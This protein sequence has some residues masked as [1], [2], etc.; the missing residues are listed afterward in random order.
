MIGVAVAAGLTSAP[1]AYAI[2]QDFNRARGTYGYE[3]TNTAGFHSGDFDG[4]E[5]HAENDGPGISGEF[6]FIGSGGGQPYDFDAHAPHGQGVTNT[7]N[8]HGGY[9]LVDYKGVFSGPLNWFGGIGQSIGSFPGLVFDTGNPNNAPQVPPLSQVLASAD[10]LAPAGKQFRYYINSPYD[11]QDHQ[12]RFVGTGTGA[13]QT[14]GGT[15]M[16]AEQIGGGAIPAN[17]PP[18]TTPNQLAMTVQFG[19]GVGGNEATWDDGTTT[20]VNAVIRLDNLTFTPATVTWGGTIGGNWSTDS[21]WKPLLTGGIPMAPSGRNATAIFGASAS[22][23]TVSLDAP[24]VPPHQG[25][26]LPGGDYPTSNNFYVG[27]LVF[28]S[29]QSYTLAGPEPIHIDTT[30]AN[31]VNLAGPGGLIQAVTGSHTISA[32]V[33]LQRSTTI[34]VASPNTLTISGALSVFASDGQPVTLSKTGGGTAIVNNIR[35]TGS[36]NVAGG[37]L[38][39]APNSTAAGVSYI[40]GNIGIGAAK[41]DITDNKLVT[42]Q[43]AGTWNGSAYTDVTGLV[44]SGR[45][46]SSLPLWDGDGIV[47]SQTFAT[48][49]DYH[50]I[51]VASAADIGITATGVWAGQTVTSTD[52]LV[53]YTYGGDANLDGKINILDY[54]R[55]DQGIAASLTGWSN[56]DFNYDGKVNVLDYA[57]IIDSNIGTQGPAFFTSGDAGNVVAVPE[58][59]S[60]AVILLAASWLAP[61]RRRRLI[62]S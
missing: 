9:F 18:F 40:P 49:G 20:G 55:I 6:F 26:G 36:L 43:T 33:I 5:Y 15:L 27:T 8:D 56:G 3:L 60:A 23:Q 16:Q 54:V 37:V 28:D 24:V 58:P 39:V 62:A 32:P 35:V 25:A 46:G 47:T 38:Q 41:L 50:S 31:G 51:G 22:P 11:G 29:A 57:P 12:F 7:P 1:A 59:S 21:N 53:M 42:K 44:A 61:S 48:N 52:T 34:D 14:V 19:S 30:S 10:I 13:W 45:N 17:G 2:V 4:Q